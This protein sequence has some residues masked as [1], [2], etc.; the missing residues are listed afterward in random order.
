MNTCLVKQSHTQGQAFLHFPLIFDVA[1]PP[2][3]SLGTEAKPDPYLLTGC[4]AND[5]RWGLQCYG[6]ILDNSPMVG[7]QVPHIIDYSNWSALL[8]PYT[9]ALRWT[10]R[11]RHT[12]RSED[13]LQV[14]VLTF[15]SCLRH[16]LFAALQVSK[17]FSCLHPS[18]LCRHAGIPDACGTYCVWLLQG[19]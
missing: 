14:S 6:S 9:L 10:D 5:A 15:P 19:M 4:G 3:S 17:R 2:T 11:H 7:W 18:F 1:S 12:W 16:N 8:C 13:A